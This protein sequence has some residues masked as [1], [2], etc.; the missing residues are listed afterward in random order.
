MEE[1]G[2]FQMIVLRPLIF[3]IYLQLNAPK[4]WLYSYYGEILVFAIY[5]ILF[6]FSLMEWTLF[7]N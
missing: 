1:T 5:R 3:F 6:Y 7:I 2:T 4:R